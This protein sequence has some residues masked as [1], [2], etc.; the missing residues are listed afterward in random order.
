MKRIVY[1]FCKHVVNMVFSRNV[2]TLVFAIAKLR[3]NLSKKM[4]ASKPL[5]VMVL[6]LTVAVA[7]L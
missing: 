6:T 1:R 5:I 7:S 4:F 3:G 2:L